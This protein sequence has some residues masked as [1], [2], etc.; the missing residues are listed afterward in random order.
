MTFEN[1]VG[2]TSGSNMRPGTVVQ[3]LLLIYICDGM[4]SSQGMS[5]RPDMSPRHAMASC[6]DMSTSHAMSE[7]QNC[8]RLNLDALTV[9]EALVNTIRILEMFS[10]RLTLP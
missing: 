9:P 4:S 1:E 7:S 2:M 5:S 3:K 10:T 8:F 6:H